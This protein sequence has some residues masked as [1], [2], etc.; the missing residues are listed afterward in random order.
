MQEWF[1][2]NKRWV[3]RSDGNIPPNIPKLG[4]STSSPG[5]RCFY[6]RKLLNFIA[7]IFPIL[8]YEFYWFAIKWGPQPSNDLYVLDGTYSYPRSVSR[9]LFGLVLGDSKFISILRATAKGRDALH[10]NLSVSRGCP[11]CGPPD[12][13]VP[14][15]GHRWWWFVPWGLEA[16]TTRKES[17][18]LW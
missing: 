12:P 3:K 8:D 11:E 13:L 10:S 9:N 4:P 15:R 18:W 7:P 2:T 17:S 16:P 14:C 6:G 5:T 1:T